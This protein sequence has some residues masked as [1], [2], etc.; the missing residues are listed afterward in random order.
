MALKR[1]TRIAFITEIGTENMIERG[2]MTGQEKGI[3]R[4]NNIAV[5]K[6]GGGRVGAG[7]GEKGKARSL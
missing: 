4:S 1:E 2:G 5:T 3:G 7:K 6:K